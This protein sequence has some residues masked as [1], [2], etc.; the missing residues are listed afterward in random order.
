ML[1]WYLPVFTIGKSNTHRLILV[2]DPDP[3]LHNNRYKI[4]DKKSANY[5]RWQCITAIGRA[6]MKPAGPGAKLS[7]S[8]QAPTAEE[9]ESRVVRF[10]PDRGDFH[11]LHGDKSGIPGKVFD[12]FAPNH[13][14]PL[15]VPEAYRGRSEGAAL[16]G[17]P[18]LVVDLTICPPGAGPVLH[19]HHKTTENFMCLSGRFEISWGESGEQNLVL[20]RYDFFSVP[21][22][23]FRTF[24]NITAEPAWLL[25][26]IQIP[27]EEQDDDV[28]LGAGLAEELRQEFGEDMLQKLKAIGFQ[29]ASAA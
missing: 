8:K 22:G 18:G 1:V 10:S 11:Q 26:L 16:K 28:D 23:I 3:G 24:K 25:V 17:L 4:S 9:M 19:R 14:Y 7:M 29:F 21:P 2:F 12:R 13:V 20:N 15:L 6:S 5:M 27:S